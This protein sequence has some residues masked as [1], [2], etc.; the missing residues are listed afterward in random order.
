MRQRAFFRSPG[1]SLIELTV[2]LLLLV[3]LGV[4]IAPRLQSNRFDELG[5]YH[6]SLAAIRYAHKVAITSG[7]EVQVGVAATQIR[8][9]YTG[10]PVAC[11]TAAVRNPATG[12]DFQVDAP[13]GVSV[14]GATFEYDLIGDPNQAQILTITN[15]DASTRDIVVTDETGFAFTP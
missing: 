5:F 9:D 4:F 2:V 1:F 15:A 6:E 14:A 7:C 13:P 3:L 8:L 10:V 11:G 12:N